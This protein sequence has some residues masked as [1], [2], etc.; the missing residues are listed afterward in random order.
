M[1]TE[2]PEPTCRLGYTEDDLR[3]IFPDESTRKEFFVWMY[4]QTFASCDGRE[5]DHDRREYHEACDGKKHGAA[6]FPW[7]VERFIRGGRIID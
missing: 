5:Y 4:G 1:K 6:Y 7:D 2:L 3:V